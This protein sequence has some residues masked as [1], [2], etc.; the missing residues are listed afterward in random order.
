V[1]YRPDRV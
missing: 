1:D